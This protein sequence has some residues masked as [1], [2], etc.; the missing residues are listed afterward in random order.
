MKT[1]RFN[2]KPLIHI[3][4]TWNYA[5]REARKGDWETYARDRQRFL[6]RI[7]RAAIILDYIFNQELRNKIY[8]QQLHP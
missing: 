7:Q 1:V 5:Y 6:V 8:H 2:T 4:Y 3:M